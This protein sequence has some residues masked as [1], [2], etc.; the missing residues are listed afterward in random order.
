MQA[1]GLLQRAARPNSNVHRSRAEGRAGGP[2]WGP[3]MPA[4]CA[5]P[6]RPLRVRGDPREGDPGGPRIGAR[7]LRPGAP[8]KPGNLK[9]WRPGAAGGGVR[10]PD[11]QVPRFPARR[12]PRP[13]RIGPETAESGAG[14][15]TL[16]A[17]WGPPSERR[18]G[19]A[20]GREHLDQTAPTQGGAVGCRV[21]CGRLAADAGA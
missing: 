10:F 12:A 21:R 11:F 5:R 20:W 19:R 7:R 1:P 18:A 13:L 16:P 9:G 6:G 17:T 15:A 14:P 8:R 2:P 4:L 3:R